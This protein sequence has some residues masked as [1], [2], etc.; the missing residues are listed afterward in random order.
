M[1]H[2]DK[3]FKSIL[4]NHE[5]NSHILLTGAGYTSNFGGFLAND[6]WALIFNHPVLNKHS[7]IKELARN[8]FSYE[9]I[10]HEVIE[11]EFSYDEK[12]AITEAIKSAYDKLDEKILNY[13]TARMNNNYVEINYVNQL[14]EQFAGS[15]KK[16]G[17][18]FT[19]NQDMLIERYGGLR[20]PVTLG[21]R[22]MP[23]IQ[24][25]IQYSPLPGKYEDIKDNLLSTRDFFYVKLHG[26]HNWFSSDRKKKMVIGGKKRE[27]IEKE[28][29]LL[30][31][32][33]CFEEVL[34]RPNIKLF[35]IG[36]GFGDEHINEMISS[37][38]KNNGLKLYVL[39]P[40]NPS[41]FKD[42]LIKQP[43]GQI[44][45]EGLAGYYPYN[46]KQVFPDNDK[47]EEFKLIKESY[48]GM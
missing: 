35:V 2:G 12:N 21:I 7:R 20:K 46:L 3:N 45:W 4:N 27:Q 11:G 31:Y 39:I 48:F 44:L 6:M 34:S 9:S 23:V 19:L 16:K 38:I 26:S 22:M 42:E 13:S 24:G 10:Y 18:F 15:Q 40:S 36:Y 14:I 28:P 32:L 17:F 25:R 5:I 8:N 1:D 43:Y 41:D 37:A 30:Y 29:L 47:S 33:N